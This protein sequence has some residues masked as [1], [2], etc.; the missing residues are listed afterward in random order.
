[1]IVLFRGLWQSSRCATCGIYVGAT[2]SGLP[3]LWRLCGHIVCLGATGSGKT[4]TSLRLAYGAR[5]VYGMQ[6]IFLDA[7]GEEKSAAEAQEDAAARF[8]AAM[9]LAGA[10]QVNLFPATSYNGWLGTPTVLI[11]RLLSVID[12]S[13][14]AYYRDVATN[15]V[16]LA[17]RTPATPRSSPQFLANLHLEQLERAYKDQPLA[18]ERVHRLDRRLLQEVRMRYEVF[19]G[20]VRGQLDGTLTFEDAD[21]AYL[22]IQGFTLRQEVPRLGR[23]LVQDFTHY[24]SSRR[25]PGTQT[26][27]I[28]DEFGALA[29]SRNR[30]RHKP[31]P[32]GTL[33]GP[34]IDSAC[35]PLAPGLK[36][37]PEPRG[38]N[39]F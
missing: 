29:T 17:L 30:T 18:L 12:L 4:E 27:L 8:V 19:F 38:A 2:T 13:E 36:S 14:S 15:A 20:V 23:F 21:A 39:W 35:G 6:I 1:M 25:R 16:T 10:A 24:I 11:N 34:E 31:E 5:K 28:I 33:V 26:L 9:R 32:R 3:C 7:K 22:R 37:E